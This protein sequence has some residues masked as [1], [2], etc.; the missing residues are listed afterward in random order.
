MS[1]SVYARH[2]PS[3]ET[4]KYLKLKDGD[5]VK[6]RIASEPAISVY[7]QGQRP[8]YSWVIF[9]RDT[10]QAQIYSAGVLVFGDLRDLEPDWGLPTEFDIR[11]KRTGSGM[12]DTSYSVTPIK[13][14]D[15]LTPEQLSE[16]EKIDLPKAIKGKWL[17]A[18]IDDHELPEPV[19]DGLA[20]ESPDSPPEYTA[21]EVGGQEEEIDLKDVPF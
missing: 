17:S 11:I 1:N 14:S 21:R 3:G 13:E 7:K 9:N 12:N 20:A 4:G 18:Y 6:M 10:K 2:N 5:A 15:D 16:V 8:R 19:T